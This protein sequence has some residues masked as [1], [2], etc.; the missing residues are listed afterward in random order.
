M[1]AANSLGSMK[2]L[3]SIVAISS[4]VARHALAYLPLSQPLRAVL[5]VLKIRA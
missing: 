3:A 4:P 2:L 5:A 1:A